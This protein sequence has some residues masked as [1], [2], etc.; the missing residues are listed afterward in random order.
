VCDHSATQ[1]F[2]SLDCSPTRPATFDGC[3]GEEISTRQGGQR[4]PPIR[5]LRSSMLNSRGEANRRVRTTHDASRLGCPWS[6]LR[7]ENAAVGETRQGERAAN[8]HS[9]EI[10]R[11]AKVLSFLKVIRN[12]RAINHVC[13]VGK[14]VFKRGRI[15]MRKVALLGILAVAGLLSTSSWAYSGDPYYAYDDPSYDE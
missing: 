11:Y 12:R 7:D 13:F 15:S 8:R 4:I 14:I 1:Q 3:E 9:G 5:H 6:S 2:P 10:P